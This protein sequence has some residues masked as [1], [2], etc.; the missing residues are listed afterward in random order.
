MAVEKTTVAKNNDRITDPDLSTQYG[1][2]FVERWDHL[3]NWKQRAAGEERFFEKILWEA[4]AQRVLDAAAGTG[5]HSVSLAHA[6]FDVTGVDA[7]AEMVNKAVANAQEKGVDVDFLQ[8]DWRYLS[9]SVSGRF[10][11]IVCLGSSFPHLF[12]ES[13]R[14]RALTEFHALLNPGGL[15]I[16]DHR[17][18]DAIRARRFRS[19]GDYYYC[20]D[21]VDISI[22]EVSDVL[23][24]FRYRFPDDSV[25]HLEVYPVRDEELRGLL[26]QAGFFEQR[27]FGDFQEEFDLLD[28]DFIIHTA[29]K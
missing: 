11:A 3:I 27:T 24:R 18:F 16:V 6:G 22:D 10:D 7:S 14:S 28:C 29:K 26:T 9:Q 8:A 17:N 1:A 20:G 21:G 5:Y 25:H 4:G 19:S 15:L 23:C 2:D 12:D 13:D